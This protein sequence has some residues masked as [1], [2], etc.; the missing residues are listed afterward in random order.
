M[1]RKRLVLQQLGSVKKTYTPKYNNLQKL[2]LFLKKHD[3]SN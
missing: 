3:G 2:Q 1:A